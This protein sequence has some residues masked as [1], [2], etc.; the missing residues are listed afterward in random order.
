MRR[1]EA[2]S[3]KPAAETRPFANLR[4]KSVPMSVLMTSSSELP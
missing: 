2:K 4:S 1:R 3:I